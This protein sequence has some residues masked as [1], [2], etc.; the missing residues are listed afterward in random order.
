MAMTALALWSWSPPAANTTA[1]AA[2]A[3]AMPA[4]PPVSHRAK[5]PG[6]TQCSSGD[7]A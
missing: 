6:P 3:T 4:V 7:P 5:T 2:S 1:M